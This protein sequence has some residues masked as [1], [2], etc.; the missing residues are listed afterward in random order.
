LIASFG[1]HHHL[2]SFDSLGRVKIELTNFDV[3]I[4]SGSQLFA[5]GAALICV[6]QV[7]RGQQFLCLTLLLNQL[8]SLKTFRLLLRTDLDNYI[9]A[10]SM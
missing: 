2:G 3:C 10:K 1:C 6:D 7:S 4:T 9:A 8:G 5:W